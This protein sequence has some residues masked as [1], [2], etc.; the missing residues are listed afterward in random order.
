MREFYLH[1]LLKLMFKNHS[2]LLRVL[3]VFIRFSTTNRVIFIIIHRPIFKLIF[4]FFPS[5]PWNRLT[6]KYIKC[7]SRRWKVI[8]TLKTIATYYMR[9]SF[10][11][12]FSF[13]FQ[14]KKK[15]ISF[16]FFHTLLN[17]KLKIYWSHRE[18]DESFILLFSQAAK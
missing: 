14:N 16:F 1:L 18:I 15:K 12:N 3:H 10:K 9:I 2:R 17:K 6:E 4:F 7:L 8:R 11:F 13:Y 5:F